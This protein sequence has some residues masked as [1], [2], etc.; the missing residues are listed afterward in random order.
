M[1]PA[2]IALFVYNRL[3]HTCRTVESL[4]NNE[5]AAESELFVFSDGARSEG[6]GENVSAVRE[7]LHTITGFRK[8]TIIERERNLGLARSIISGVTEVIERSGRI[9]V[10]EDDLV[11]APNFLSYMNAALDTYRDNPKVFSISG[12]GFPIEIPRSYAAQVY[13]SYRSSSW[14]WATWEDRWRKADWEVS[15]FPSLSRDRA[16]RRRFNR[17]G[18]DLFDMLAL[19]QQGKI[20]SWAIRWCYAH[21]RHEAYCLFPVR[22]KILNIGC[23]LSGTNVPVTDRYAVVL[24]DGSEPIRLPR[25]IEPDAEILGKFA[26]FHRHSLKERLSRL[27][28]RLLR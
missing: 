1:T 25:E 27:A 13:L 16:A 18:D 19:Q 2:P 21:F 8:V 24:D 28:K 26:R 4:K 20:D 3:R 17:G 9:I 10:M 23:D 7:Y 15:D 12:Y 22:S 11:S 5:L 14:G 6:D